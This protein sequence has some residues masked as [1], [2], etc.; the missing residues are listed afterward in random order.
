MLLCSDVVKVSETLKPVV[1]PH[2]V[3]V[4]AF[5][6]SS[7]EFSISLSN[8]NPCPVR[9]EISVLSDQS[10]NSSRQQSADFSFAFKPHQNVLLVEPFSSNSAVKVMF[11]QQD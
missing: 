7:Q 11:C 3:I 4:E 2:S 9:I 8:L 5:V 1:I 10:D 6:G